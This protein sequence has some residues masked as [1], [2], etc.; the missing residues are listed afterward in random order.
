[1]LQPFGKRL[2][3]SAVARAWIAARRCHQRHPLSVGRHYLHG[4]RAGPQLGRR[5]VPR[6]TR[7]GDL[8]I[9]PMVNGVADAGSGPA[10]ADVLPRAIAHESLPLTAN[11]PI[12]ATIAAG[13]DITPRLHHG[14]GPW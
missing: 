13:N 14:R 4:L 2:V 5:C 8:A 1:M 11:A 7:G 6:R 9:A 3:R 12:H 10:A